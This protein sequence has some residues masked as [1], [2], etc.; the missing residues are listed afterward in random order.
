MKKSIFIAMTAFVWGLCFIVN[1]YAEI[2]TAEREALIDLYNSTN[3]DNWA[4]KDFNGWKLP[5]LA[6]DGFA[7]AGT[8]CVWM[9]V[10]CDSEENH[11]T[12]ISLFNNK[13][14]G[15]LPASIEKFENLTLLDLG[16]K[17]DDPEKNNIGGTLPYTL[18]NL[19]NLEYLYLDNNQ[20]TGS[21]PISLI[22]LTKLADGENNFCN[23]YLYTSEPTL[24]AFLNSKQYGV[25]VEL[26]NWQ[27]CQNIPLNWVKITGNVF[28]S[29]DAQSPLCAMVLINGQYMFTCE[30]SCAGDQGKYSLVVPLDKNG[31][32]T[33]FGF[34][35]GR[36]PF[37]QIISQESG[38]KTE[39]QIAMNIPE[40][41]REIIIT[42]KTEPA[43]A[44]PEWVKISGTVADENGTPLCTMVLANGQYMFT[45]DENEGKYALE[46]PMDANGEITLFSFCDGFLPFK[47]TFKP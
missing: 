14:S 10:K 20:L 8:E 15:T 1:L 22:N 42:K 31:E 18:G 24:C 25:N 37:K 26:Q 11:V 35:D 45:C 9:G 13:L 30:G 32:V 46:V 43:T 27:D 34:C 40:N 21:V 16:S 2:P 7:K 41:E 36:A 23:N 29:D 28:T 17:S 47:E 4:N 39:I 44:N 19:K 12:E 5:P 3:G 33:I 38:Q 6:S